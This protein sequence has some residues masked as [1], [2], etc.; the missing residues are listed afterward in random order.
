MDEFLFLYAVTPLAGCVDM[1]RDIR[2]TPQ[3]VCGFKHYEHKL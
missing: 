3:E 1:T 2:H